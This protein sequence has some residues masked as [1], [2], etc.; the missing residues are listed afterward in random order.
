MLPQIEVLLGLNLCHFVGSE[1]VSRG[2][3]AGIVLGRVRQVREYPRQGQG[4]TWLYG[5][6][7]GQK[8]GILQWG[9]IFDRH[10]QRML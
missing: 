2:V 3:F 1:G 9:V 7:R 8:Q 5:A 10:Q 4:R 6:A